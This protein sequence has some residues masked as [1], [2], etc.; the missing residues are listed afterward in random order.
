MTGFRLYTSNQLEVLVEELADDLKTPL[1]SPLQ[2]EVIVVQ[3]LGMARWIAMELAAREGICAN[4]DFPFPNNYIHSIF[5]KILPGVDD[6]TGFE[7]EFLTWRI[8]KLLPDVIHRPGFEILKK[9]V[10]G[11]TSGLKFFQLAERIADTFDQYLLYRPQMIFRW[12]QGEE[13][14]WQAELWRLVVS[15]FEKKFHRAALRKQFMEA[16]QSTPSNGADLP[17]RISVFGISTLPQFHIDVLSLISRFTQV[18]L[19]LMN[20]CREFWFDIVSDRE[21][22]RTTNRSKWQNISTEALHLE[23]GNS[24][25]ASMGTLGRDFFDI[26]YQSDFEEYSNYIPPHKNELLFQ[27]QYDILD[28]YE[29]KKENEKRIISPN[30]RSIQIHS[31]HSPMREI[32]VLHDQLLDL[33][34]QNQDLNPRDILVM[35]PDIETYAPYIQAVFEKPYDDPRRIRFSIADRSIRKESQV[36]E[37]FLSL[38][39]LFGSRFGVAQVLSIL[40]SPPVWKKFDLAESDLET[41][42][43]W[44]RETRIRWGIDAAHRGELDLPATSENTWQAGLNRLLLGYAMPGRDENMFA[45]IL[46]FD[47]IEGTETAVLGNFLEFAEKLFD[48]VTSLK[49]ERTLKEWSEFLKAMLDEF[50]IEDSETQG[51]IQ[52]L[53]QLLNDLVRFAGKSHF[54]ER[55]D[56]HVIKHYLTRNSETR[57]FGFG[58]ITGG[59]TFCAMLPMRSIPAKVICLVGMNNDLFPRQT[60]RLGFDLIARNPCKGDRSQRNDDRY[61]FLEALLSAREKL[62]I[63]FVGQSIQDNSARPPSVLVSELEDYISDNFCL[64]DGKIRETINVKHRLQSFSPEYFKAD[65]PLFSYAED[66]LE[67]A[68]TFLRPK[69]APQLFLSQGLA[70]PEDDWK[71][72]TIKDLCDFFFNPCRFLLSKRLGIQLED[73]AVALDEKEPFSL[74]S[75]DKYMLQQKILEKKLT[76]QNVEAIRSLARAEGQLPH[77]VVGECSYNNLRVEVESFASK[78]TPYFQTA[79]L[80]AMNIDLEIDEFR[81]VG[82]IDPIYANGLIHFRY[83]TIKPKDIIR[84]WIFHVLLN[85]VQAENYPRES[86]LIGLKLKSQKLDF[87][88]WHVSA[89]E[90]GLNILQQLLRLYWQGLKQPLHFFPISSFE[91]ARR[92]IGGQLPEDALRFARKNWEG[93]DW[94]AGER[95]EA[96]MGLCFGKEDPLDEEF[97]KLSLEIFGEFL[98]NK[99][100]K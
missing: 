27:I 84:L 55:I 76:Q 24:L 79:P 4:I 52:T 19:F 33:F 42:R 88:V 49:Q 78:A 96:Y 16:L 61:L 38:L 46:P 80:P 3:S 40:E 50:F 63:S 37:T 51:Q 31:C 48:R 89:L 91:Y 86:S 36:I 75:L 10:E 72:L 20:P 56:I 1:S 69:T 30:D 7:K 83:A 43:T 99:S 5:K 60:P 67:A 74:E 53:R 85:T 47:N 59:V 41:I 17:E 97:E 66:K 87:T 77:G 26:I 9:Y 71:T 94:F 28:L 58:F 64:S 25:L 8:L 34:Q 92:V 18:T 22:S 62:Y 68:R 6:E 32:E 21:L 39:D 73:E 65:S 100:E 45:G 23:K 14:H 44:V 95:F 57:G 90:N 15:G 70:E 82:K 2:K 12:E 54:D 29:K 35:I 81:I 93:D 98:D 13:N 11:E